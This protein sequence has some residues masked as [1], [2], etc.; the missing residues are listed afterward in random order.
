MVKT[1]HVIPYPAYYFMVAIK[2]K[3]NFFES[4]LFE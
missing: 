1:L 4:P 2:L 3:K